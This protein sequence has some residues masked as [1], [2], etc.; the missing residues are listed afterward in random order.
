[1]EETCC[2][3]QV[4]V[5]FCTCI[6]KQDFVQKSLKGKGNVLFFNTFRTKCRIDYLLVFLVFLSLF[7]F[8]RKAFQSSRS[9][10]IPK[11]V[12]VSKDVRHLWFIEL[13]SS[14]LRS[15]FSSERCSS[16]PSFASRL[17]LGPWLM[18]LSTSSMCP[19]LFPILTSVV[20]L[21][22]G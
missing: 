5:G 7:I 8:L 18:Q 9:M 11:L 12:P 6:R 13:G 19:I 2:R 4:S 21:Q 17:F 22:H 3:H 20:R 1:M 10:L 14:C 16:S 15:I